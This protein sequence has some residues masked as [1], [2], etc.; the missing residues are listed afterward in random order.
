MRFRHL[1]LGAIPLLAFLAMPLAAHATGIPYWDSIVPAGVQKC[2]AGWAAF[3]Q[4]VNN[5]IAFILTILIFIVTPLL[6]VWAGFLYVVAP[7]NPANRTKANHILTNTVVGL[8][9]ALFAWVIVNA[10]LTGITVY[11]DGSIGGVDKFVS[12]MFSTTQNACLIDE[13]T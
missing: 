1:L 10:V 9:I 13:S 6:I 12:A 8:A 11:K 5:L 7:A 4:L 2:A 3:A